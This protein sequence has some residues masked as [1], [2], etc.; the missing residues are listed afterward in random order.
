MTN[1]YLGKSINILKETPINRE[2]YKKEKSEK[3][4]LKQIKSY[5]NKR[6]ENKTIKSFD[7]IG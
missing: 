3:N 4:R 7:N 5:N 6:F 1:N 2:I